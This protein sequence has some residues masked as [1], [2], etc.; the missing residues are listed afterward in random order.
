[1]AQES[2]D[3]KLSGDSSRPWDKWIPPLLVIGS[4]L[5]SVETGP[6]SH[7]ISIAFI[8]SNREIRNEISSYLIRHL[9]D[10]PSPAFTPPQG[11]L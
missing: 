1:M 10:A 11:T 2:S 4:V 9:Q 5:R 7:D 3:S 6:G 8:G